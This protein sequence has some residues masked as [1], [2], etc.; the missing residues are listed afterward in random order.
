MIFKKN[1]TKNTLFD[2]KILKIKMAPNGSIQKKLDPLF[3]YIL[4]QNKKW[5]KVVNVV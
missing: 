2:K 5:K 1:L 4:L 3:E